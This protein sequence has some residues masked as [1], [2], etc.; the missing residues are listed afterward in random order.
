VTF[1]VFILIMFL[2]GVGLVA[3]VLIIV[4]DSISCRIV[5][6]TF[7]ILCGHFVF[8]KGVILIGGIFVIFFRA[9]GHVVVEV[10]LVFTRFMFTL[11]CIL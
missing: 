4:L 9:L 1:V 6:V 10:V 7:M 2:I 8:F 11:G 3:M 5:V